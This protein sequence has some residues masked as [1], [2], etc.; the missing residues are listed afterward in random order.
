ELSA[1]VYYSLLITPGF[2]ETNADRFD[3][4]RRAHPDTPL[5]ETGIVKLF[6]DGVIETNTAFMLAPYAND[7]STRG[8]PNYTR[9]ELDRIVQTMDPRRWQIMGHAPRAG[10]GRMGPG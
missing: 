8:R 2:T 9:Q 10:A 7:P 6:L 1:R 4:L 5:L 3:A